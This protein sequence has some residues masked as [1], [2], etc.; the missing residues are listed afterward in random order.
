MRNIGFLAFLILLHF[1]G[2][3]EA[4]LNQKKKH[5]LH[6]GNLSYKEKMYQDAIRYYREAIGVDSSFAQAYNNLGIVYFKTGKVNEAIIAYNKC[7][8]I[9]KSLEILES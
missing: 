5:F 8:Y 3:G 6:K 1:T 4:R 7:I 9:D 2:C